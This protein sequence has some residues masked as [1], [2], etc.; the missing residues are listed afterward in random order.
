MQL[1]LDSSHS[2]ILLPELMFNKN[3][4]NWLEKPISTTFLPGSFIT[5]DFIWSFVEL[6]SA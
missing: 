2:Q 5:V 1:D 3:Q 4:I 6:R